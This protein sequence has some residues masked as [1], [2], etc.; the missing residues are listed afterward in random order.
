VK[1]KNVVIDDWFFGVSAVS[2]D[3]YASP[4]EFP[5]A[6]GAFRVTGK[7]KLSGK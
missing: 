6:A 5:G 7:P 1:L 3:G 4:I 2:K